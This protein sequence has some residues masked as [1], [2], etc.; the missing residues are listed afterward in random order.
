MNKR[1][2]HILAFTALSIA[3]YAQTDPVY[4][5]DLP[6]LIDEASGLACPHPDTCW[7]YN[8]SDDSQRIYLLSAQGAF[9]GQRVLESASQVDYEDMTM[10]DEGKLYIGDF[11]NNAND[12][13]NLGIYICSPNTVSGSLIPASYISLT[14][15]DQSEFPP[16]NAQKNFDIEAMIHQGTYLYLFSRNRTSPY[17]GLTKM[18]RL[19]AEPG[20]HIAE[21][22]GEF[23]GNLSEPYNS[24][25]S[26]DISPD[27]SRMAL[28]SNGSLFLFHDL[29]SWPLISGEFTYN[30][31][32]FTAPF[33]GIAF[34]DDCTA[35]VVSESDGTIPGKLYSLNTCEIVSD[36]NEN[37]DP[38][39]L[40]YAGGAV[41]FTAADEDVNWRLFDPRGRELRLSMQGQSILIAS[42]Y[43]PGIYLL[44]YRSA[45]HSGV[46]R[47]M[48]ED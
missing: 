32:S 3:S 46:F 17:T 33:E 4:I 18:Y 12:R 36:L 39:L 28:L 43:S 22:M 1:F 30:F 6:L 40:Y 45:S 25:T 41:Y 14:L 9:L 31:F 21:L 13:Q 27:G 11:G 2:A 37:E 26:A 29:D 7:T 24:I 10:D 5:S 34:I 20:P 16:T 48:K 19:T 42:S 15:S 38:L 44:A 35:L 23:F 47:F 8:D